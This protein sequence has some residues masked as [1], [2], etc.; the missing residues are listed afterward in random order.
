MLPS[1][2]EM[3]EMLRELTALQLLGTPSSGPRRGSISPS[4]FAS[5][6]GAFELALLG[7]LPSSWELAVAGL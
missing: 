7:F 4:A 6:L 5:V 1:I 2:E 3:N